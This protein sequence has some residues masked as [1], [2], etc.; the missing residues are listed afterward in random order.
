M[1]NFEESFGKAMAAAARTPKRA[2]DRWGPVHQHPFQVLY[3]RSSGTIDPLQGPTDR[4]STV[5][6]AAKDIRHNFDNR[7]YDEA[8]VSEI[9]TGRPIA[10]IHRIDRSRSRWFIGHRPTALS[11]YFATS[12]RKA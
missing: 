4:F 1:S 7:F 2:P 12:E 9:V 11:R 5:D 3:Y 6:K 8:H 10:T